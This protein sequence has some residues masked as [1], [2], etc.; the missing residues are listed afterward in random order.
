MAAEGVVSEAATVVQS[1]R[2]LQA[3]ERSDRDRVVS[4]EQAEHEYRK[5]DA[6]R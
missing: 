2:D 6:A 5:T 4:S 3:A 1:W